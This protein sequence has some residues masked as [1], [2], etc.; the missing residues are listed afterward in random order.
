MGIISHGYSLLTNG[1]KQ[2]TIKKEGLKNNPL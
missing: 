1:D 2:I